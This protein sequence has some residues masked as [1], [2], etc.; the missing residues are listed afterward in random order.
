[1]STFFDDFIWSD[2][3]R[4]QLASDSEA[5]NASSFGETDCS[6][7]QGVYLGYRIQG[8]VKLQPNLDIFNLTQPARRRQKGRGP[9]SI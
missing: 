4:G 6:F 2:I 9:N 3:V 5:M 7:H 8:I 1:V